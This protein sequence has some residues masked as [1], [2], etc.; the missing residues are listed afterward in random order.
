MRAMQRDRNAWREAQASGLLFECSWTQRHLHRHQI[1]PGQQAGVVLSHETSQ[2]S[3][4]TPK[5]VSPQADGLLLPVH[6]S[7]L[8]QLF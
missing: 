3:P 4:H 8:S 7:S 2:A 5:L 1:E 6:P